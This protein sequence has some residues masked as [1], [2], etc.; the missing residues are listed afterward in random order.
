M[1]AFYSLLMVPLRVEAGEQISI[2]LLLRDEKTV[3]FQ[4][5]LKKLELL[6]T[7]LPSQAYK[8][9][10]HSLK[11]IEASLVQHATPQLAHGYVL[12]EDERSAP[13][14]VQESYVDYLSRYGNNLLTLTEPKPF[15][16]PAGAEVFRKLFQKLVAE[17]AVQ[18]ARTEGKLDI[19]EVLSNAFYPQ[20]KER[21]NIGLRLTSREVPSLFLPIQVSFIGKNDAPVVGRSIDFS[22]RDYNL[23][24]DLT[25]LYTL[26]KAFEEIGRTGGK[27]YAIGKEPDKEQKKNHEMWS[28]I[29]QFHT[30][31]FVDYREVDQVVSYMETHEVSPFLE[32]NHDA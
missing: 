10:T 16:F 26:V 6:K 13:L 24:H 18:E 2:G 1:P 30:V 19:E 9:L 22:K 14:F 5:S 25:E 17:D 32:T 31:D 11:D 3:Y 8:L 15:R 20:I 21:V 27:Y 12:F 29:H 4:Y 23:G 28:T 7:L